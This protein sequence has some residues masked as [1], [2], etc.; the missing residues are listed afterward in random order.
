MCRMVGVVF[1]DQFPVNVLTDLR[2]ISRE[3]E[4]PGRKLRGHRDGWGI[5]SF[6]DGSPVYL[7][8]SPSWAAEDSSFE[9]AVNKASKLRPPSIVIGHIRAASRGKAKL[10]NTHPFIVGGL[11]L[12]HNG[13]IKGLNFATEGRRLGGTDSELLALALADR[14]EKEHNLRIAL[15]AVIQEEVLDREF[16]GAVLLVSDGKTL[17]GYRDYSENGSYYNLRLAVG[18]QSIVLFQETANGIDGSVSQVKRRELVSIGLDLEV[19]REMIR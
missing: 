13:T 19:K 15:K 10:V 1:R 8:R 3:G 14:Y 2:T 17:C 16:T 5:A 11:V 9:I 12:G 6:V 7:G 4:I 18:K